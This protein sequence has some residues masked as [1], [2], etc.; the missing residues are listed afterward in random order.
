LVYRAVVFLIALSHVCKSSRFVSG[1]IFVFKVRLQLMGNIILRQRLALGNRAGESMRVGKN[2]MTLYK[3]ILTSRL[4]PL[5][6]G[7]APPGPNAALTHPKPRHAA[8]IK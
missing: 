6:Q 3:P 5:A 4:M 8:R 2:Q 7:G 1:L